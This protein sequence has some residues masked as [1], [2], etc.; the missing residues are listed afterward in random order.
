MCVL[1]ILLV[2]L[3]CTSGLRVSESSEYSQSNVTPQA[4][5]L[6]GLAWFTLNEALNNETGLVSA[7]KEWLGS[8]RNTG[9]VSMASVS[10]GFYVGNAIDQE[11]NT[12]ALIDLNSG[13]DKEVLNCRVELGIRGPGS[14]C[15]T[16]RLGRHRHRDNI[17]YT[18]YIV[19]IE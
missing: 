1:G 2:T 15:G 6:P 12:R 3:R 19:L 10:D 7:T 14:A 9:D 8:L 18:G 5:L 4:M 13:R 17:A 16:A 11:G